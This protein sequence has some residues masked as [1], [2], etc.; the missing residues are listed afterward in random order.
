MHLFATATAGSKVYG[1][2]RCRVVIA[3]DPFVGFCRVVWNAHVREMT[4]L[5][6]S[7]RSHLMNVV[8]DTESALRVLL[9]PTR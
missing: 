5:S 2:D 4:D 7:E 9:H 1:D 8:F 6:T 3:E